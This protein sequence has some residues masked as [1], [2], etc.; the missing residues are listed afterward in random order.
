MGCLKYCNELLR[1]I[2]QEKIFTSLNNHYLHRKDSF[3]MEFVA[4]FCAAK[5]LAVERHPVKD[6]RSNVQESF[7]FSVVISGLETVL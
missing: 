6:I 5:G 7:M 2:K 4:L 3:F 1:I